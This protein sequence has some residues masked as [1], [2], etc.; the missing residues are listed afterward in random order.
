MLRDYQ[1]EMLKKAL[2]HN[3]LGLT[4]PTAF[5]KTHFSFA[6]A[7]AL[8][9]KTA[10]ITYSNELVRQYIKSFDIPFLIG[11]KHYKKKA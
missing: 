11:K 9:G 4:L 3:R 6:L 10:I 8:K 5:G 1:E 7:N 2:K